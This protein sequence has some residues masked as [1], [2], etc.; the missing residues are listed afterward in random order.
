VKGRQ[1]SANNFFLS[2][3]N[4]RKLFNDAPHS[5][6]CANEGLQGARLAAKLPKLYP[7]A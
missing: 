4:E 6:E 7:A 1:T 5:A 2:H 3:P